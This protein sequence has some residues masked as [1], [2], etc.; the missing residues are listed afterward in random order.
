MSLLS[1]ASN[2]FQI[3]LND[4]NLL[5]ILSLLLVLVHPGH[6]A[7]PLTGIK[8]EIT[9]KVETKQ[10]MLTLMLQ[11]MLSKHTGG[12]CCPVAPLGPGIPTWPYEE[13]RIY[14]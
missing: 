2:T 8:T 10:H 3:V 12:P 4:F 7:H 11:R 13:K 14:Y 1:Q 6:L 5:Q 9:Y